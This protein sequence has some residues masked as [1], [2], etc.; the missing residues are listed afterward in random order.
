MKNFLNILSLLFVTFSFAQTNLTASEN[1]IY[2]KTCLNNDCTKTSENVQYFDSWGRPVQGV[3]IK[4]SPLGNDVVSHIEYDTY[5][6]QVKDYLPVPQTGTQNGAFYPSPLANASSLYGNEKIYS[7]KL[8]ENS[9]LERIQQQVPLGNAWSNKP[10]L[11]SYD[12]NKDGEV[13]KY[14]VTTTWVE[15]RTNSILSNNGNYVVNTLAKNMVTDEDGNVTIEFT[16]KQGQMILARK[17]LSATEKADTYYVYNEFNQLAYTL[18]PLASVSGAVSASTLDNLCYQYRYDGWNRLVEKKLP[19]KGWEYLVYDKADRLMLSQDANMRG[20]GK[21]MMTKYDQFGRIV[22]TG[23]FSSNDSRA[24]LQNQIKDLVIYDARHSTGFVRNGMNIYYTAV[25]FIPESILSVNYYDTYPAGTPAAP[26]QVMGQDILSQDAQ[27]SVISTKTLPTATYVKNIEDNGWTKNYIWYDTKGRAVGSHVINHL[28]G[29]TRTES[30]IDFTGLVKQTKTYHKRLVSDPEKTITQSFEYDL[31]GRKK[32]HYHQVDNQPQELLA[33]NT[34]NEISQLSSKKV[35]NNLQ[36][37]DYQYNIRGWMT[38]INDPSNL[39]GKL[40][41]YEMKYQSPL[42]AVSKY[43]GS[44]TEIDWKTTNDMMLRRYSY[45]YDALSRMEKGIYSEPGSSIPQNGF[46]NEIMQY[47]GNG[48][49]TSLQR[50]SYGIT[51]TASLIDNLTYN[52]TGNRLNS[53]VDQSGNYDGYS[54]VSGNVISYDD[55]GNMKDHIDKGV[56]Q[57]DYNYL[58]LPNYIKFNEQYRSRDNVGVSYN[59]N[60]KYVYRADGTKLRK[61]YTF[62]AG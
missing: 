48:N 41:G 60:T 1:Y 55:N 49:I 62:G 61:T 42:N 33:D 38:K 21:W 37:I 8:V 46:F 35:G 10:I 13:T 57:I 16:N 47:D 28:G 45:Q 19:G 59:V 51:G 29:Y 20:S 11:F 43:N 27:N 34:Y 31:Q 40:F 26:T 18:P 52:Y 3:A 30:E 9:P 39:N 5:G 24:T 12:A 2:S 58:N 36:S 4:A 23:I 7:E 44:I 50:N 6:R 56:L 25:Y 14:T 32:K 15:G 22:Y 53:V 17:M 54:D